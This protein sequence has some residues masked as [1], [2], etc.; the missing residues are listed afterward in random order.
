MDHRRKILKDGVHIDDVR[1]LIKIKCQKY[2]INTTNNK[3]IYKSNEKV[4]Y[5]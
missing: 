3:V 5:K 4:I 1:L 2:L